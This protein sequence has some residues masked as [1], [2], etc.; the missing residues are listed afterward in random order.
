MGYLQ[1]DA[2]QVRVPG[3]PFSLTCCKIVWY[4]NSMITAPTAKDLAE[5]EVSYRSFR[6]SRY[7]GWVE[8]ILSQAR[9][10]VLDLG[11]GDGAFTRPLLARGLTVV[12]SDL[13]LG[14]L[15]ALQHEA[16]CLLEADATA[17]PFREGCFDTI[18]FTEV[19]EH[20]ADRE[21]QRRALRE[22]ART[23]RPGGKLVLTT[24]NRPVYRIVVRCWS[25]FGGQKPDP[26]H[27]SELSLAELRAMVAEQYEIIA[28]RGKFGFFTWPPLQRF[29]AN[30]PG[31]CYDIMVAAT[32]KHAGR[33]APC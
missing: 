16:S 9:G 7:T 12:A 33:A 31:W 32:P 11:C 15:Q 17:L 21:A 13:S 28:V 6:P 30:R 22:F 18:I 25:W 19:L 29:F 20:L 4:H 10:A 23:L 26:T 27:F 8:G 2:V 5:R 24:P 14:R 1:D 3:A